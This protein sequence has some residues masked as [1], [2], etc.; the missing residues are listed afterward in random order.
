MLKGACCSWADAL[1]LFSALSTTGAC[2][3]SESAERRQTS[4]A[5]ALH[6]A[7]AQPVA[8]GSVEA[9]HLFRSSEERRGVGCVMQDDCD[10][11]GIDGLFF[12]FLL[13]VGEWVQKIV[14]AKR[15]DL[16]WKFP[17]PAIFAHFHT[18]FLL[19]FF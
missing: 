5:G 9:S 3:V 1:P 18:L 17:P 8:L 12:V 2:Y 14:I 13:P 6:I 10:Y 15:D 11:Q 16:F 4:Q 7:P 19:R